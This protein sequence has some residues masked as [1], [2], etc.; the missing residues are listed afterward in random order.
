[1]GEI[2]QYRNDIDHAGWRIDRHTYKDFE[3]KLRIFIDRTKE[4]VEKGNIFNNIVRN[5]TLAGIL[6]SGARET[7]I[8]N[9]W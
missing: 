9:N 1:M 7:V 6:L 2:I 4:I 5:N 8:E 3:Q